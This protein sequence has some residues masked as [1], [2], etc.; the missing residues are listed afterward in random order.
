MFLARHRTD[1]KKML[2]FLVILTVLLVFIGINYSFG[3]LPKTVKDFFVTAQANLTFTL[4]PVGIS[5]Q[6][7]TKTSDNPNEVN[8]I[9]KQTEKNINALPI[10]FEINKGQTDSKVRFLSKASRHDLFMTNNEAVFSF[11]L[12]DS[13]LNNKDN[14]RKQI[15]SL[16]KR[17]ILRLQFLESNPKVNVVGLDKLSEKSNYLMTRSPHSWK[18][19]VD[20]FSKV[21][22]ESIYE[23]IDLLYYGNQH[24]LEYDFI[25][26]PGTDVSLIKLNFLGTKKI[27]KSQ[28][29][30][31]II[32]V[33]GIEFKQ[34]KPVA[35]QIIDGER[36][37]VL[38]DYVI[39][40]N[41]EVRFEV[42]TYDN[43]QPL[44]IDPV[45]SY[46]SYLG[47]FGLDSGNSVARDSS[48]YIY[49]TGET[50]STNFPTVSGG[51]QT[52]KS[53]S[54]DVFILK[55]DPSGAALA[56]STYIGGDGDDVGQGVIVDS[57]G[58][59]YVTGKTTSTNFPTLNPIQTSFGGVTD[60]FVTKLNA[61]GNAL[62]Y[63][64]YLGGVGNENSYGAIAIDGSG[65]VLITGTTTSTN[66][67]LQNAQQA[68]IGGSADAYVTKLN[69]A[70]NALIYSTYL[71][72]ANADY[73]KGIAVD[74]L[75][76][77]YIVGTTASTNFPVNNA[78]Q[79]THGGGL[80]DVF[81]AK[82]NATGSS[83]T[84]STYLG[85]NHNDS[86]AGI[87]LD[88]SNNI[89]ITGDTQSF[90]FP[91]SNALQPSCATCS[92]GTCYTCT[93]FSYDAFVTKIDGTG[94]SLIYSSFIGGNNFDSGRAIAVDSS[95]NAYITGSTNSTNFPLV[96]PLQSSIG[97]DSDIFV[98]KVNSGGTGFI[99]S[100]YLGGSGT[101]V[102]NAI[103][104]D[105]SGSALVTGINLSG[106]FPT[107]S[108][109][110]P[111]QGG[112]YD[113]LIFKIAD[114]NT[115]GISGKITNSNGD[116]IVGVTVTLGGGQSGT[117]TSNFE[118]KYYLSNVNPLGNYTVTPSKTGY[119]FNPVNANF[120]NLNSHQTADFVG[121]TYSISGQITDISGNPINYI[122]VELTGSQTDTVTTN[123][124]GYFS[125]GAV[126][127]GGNYTV[128]PSPN[129]TTE[130][131][132]S[133][134][135]RSFTNLSANQTANFTG[136]SYTVSGR[137]LQPNGMPT[138]GVEVNVSSG[139]VV[140]C[141]NNGRYSVKL[142]PGFNYTFTP[143]NNPFLLH[144]YRFTPTSQ[145]I[146]NLSAD[147]T[148]DFTAEEVFKVE[149]YVR[150]SSSVGVSGVTVSLSG[151]Q[152]GV[153]TTN[154]SGFYSF[155]NIPRGTYSLTASKSGLV[156]S[157]LRHSI[158]LLLSDKTLDFTSS[159][160]T[161]SG[162]VKNNNALPLSNITLNLSGSGTGT[163]QTDANGNYSF[164]NLVTGGT[165]TVTPV[166]ANY[167]FN[168]GGVVFSVITENKTADFTANQAYT[169]SGKV[170]T[171]GSTGVSTATVVLSGS[172]SKT[173]QTDAGGNYSFNS[174]PPGGNYRVT[175]S[176]ANFTFAPDSSYLTALGANQTANFIA[177]PPVTT[178]PSPWSTQDIGTVGLTGGATHLSGVF[179]VTGAG[180]DIG[181]TADSF[182]YAYQTLSG[183]GMIVARVV[184]V[185]NTNSA[186]KAGVMIRQSLT[187]NAIEAS[188]FFSPAGGI[189][190]LRRN[191]AAG[192]TSST[193]FG[194]ESFPYW[195]KLMRKGNEI[196]GYKS[197]DGT[198]WTFLSSYT[199]TTTNPVYI[200]LAV[201][202]K[203]T[204]ALNNSVFDSVAITIQTP[205]HT[206][207]V[208]VS[209]P[210]S[211]TS[212]SPGSTVTFNATATDLDGTITQV[213]YFNGSTLIGTNTTT[214]Y[215]V[216]W[217]PAT[218]GTYTITARATDNSGGKT[219]SAGVNMI[220]QPNGASV[221][222]P[223][224]DAHVRDGTNANTNYGT[225]Q[226]IE[227]GT[228]STSGNTRDAYLKFDTSGITNLTGAKLRIYANLS[229]AGSLTTSVYGV[230]NTTWVESG[231]SG[232]KWS[233]KPTLGSVINSASITTTTGTWYEIDVL[234]Y[235]Q[236][237]KTAGR[238]VV[239][240][241]LHNQS[242][243][244]PFISM[245]SKESALNKPE[246]VLTTTNT[247]TPPTISGV[248]PSSG[249]E[250][251]QVTIAGSNFGATRGTSLVGF[252]GTSVSTITAWSNNSISVLVPRGATTGT[253]VVTVRGV[254]SNGILFTVAGTV[255]DSDGD[256][257]PD[258]WEQYYFGNLTQ[259]AAGDFD[260]DGI[261]NLLEYQRGLNPTKVGKP[262]AGRY[263]D[264]KVYTPLEQ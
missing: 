167:I 46:A 198:N 69:A 129:S 250:G 98:S 145:S 154:S 108:A 72:G 15:R 187:N 40:N 68:T 120:T 136:V 219:T 125:F 233:T 213:E 138:P 178:L 128:T 140:V 203:T 106:V 137:F 42:G 254:A 183:D 58:N 64:T 259:T 3:Q 197:E 31:L 220:V 186:A 230:S 76:N 92:G 209:S 27:Y 20:V 81:V 244:T 172:Q 166:N 63:S 184:N 242:V 234:S 90:N 102:G 47:G 264:L 60:A 207:Q 212:V 24:Y 19:G 157:P 141:D 109:L 50:S 204:S 228:S 192:T 170:T 94:L 185:Q 245:K 36:K 23:G 144:T 208:S 111:N 190:F 123:A 149:G 45:L 164:A 155:T 223:T 48:G 227:V 100:T 77:A 61:A 201:T 143:Q 6:Y 107:V 28:S 112:S 188:V 161:I 9:F 229:A 202:S 87:A 52:V 13:T 103:T 152:T 11:E 54:S 135:N 236:S 258:T 163:V 26:K 132:F 193:T 176:K 10:R 217:I 205:N 29:G 210:A 33:C 246:L 196:S 21:K 105:S 59:A 4:E 255:T 114:N 96:N 43:T 177:T 221:L 121:A 2:S 252:N 261:S 53:T 1:L 179:N 116:P 156:F 168:P 117:A 119:S 171:N 89:Y 38:S 211:G 150:N 262:D 80:N 30:D 231:A 83:R 88:S 49:V 224:A 62:V 73:G 78:L 146:V 122:T 39:G 34:H 249:S 93:S 79:P 35:Y 200:G 130:Y 218:P 247:G 37:E 189:S 134:V 18:T 55:L 110:Q 153:K 214:P 251:S 257:L 95:G 16:Q 91:I 57:S 8:D 85:G 118:G 165:Y 51:F 14:D 216:S 191:A 126:T 175:P 194:T 238:H 44:I 260:G 151:D 86:G 181:G 22:Y 237:E 162:Q 74:S 248:S 84:F 195:L 160:L 225:S 99:Y 174:L 232:I 71:G 182:R 199:I 159:P 147:Q 215:A 70:G 113:V 65:Q 97:G 7:E 115:F 173:T 240:L 142:K 124:G 66:F 148:L 226:N 67:P 158:P 104:T 133:P 243:A 241:A 17:G 169:I 256:G 32:D 222:N 75:S 5:S 56:Y 235:I 131:L 180:S 25:V 206:P 12:P 253:V 41:S 127:P 82:I 139:V 263:I 239:T 101:D